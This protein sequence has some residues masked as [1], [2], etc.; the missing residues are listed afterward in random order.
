[1]NILKMASET[2][3]TVRL[4]RGSEGAEWRGLPDHLEHAK[5][6]ERRPER[7]VGAQKVFILLV[8]NIS[9]CADTITI[10]NTTPR[11]VYAAIYYQQI[12]IPFMAQPDAQ[13]AT[14]VQCVDAQ[15][16]ATL[17]RP[18]RWF[19]YDRELVF[20]EDPSLLTG[21]L[22]NDLLHQYHSKNVGNLQGS[23]FYLGD[24]EGDIYAYTVLEWDAVQVPLQ[25]AQQE[26]FNMVPAIA[27]NPYKNQIAY[28]RQGN[29]LCDQEKAYLNKR[30]PRVAK[31]L[32]QF[33]GKPLGVK[34]PTIALVCS[35]GG[36]RAMLYT[37][38]ALKGI[39]ELQLLDAITYAVGL[40]G[41]TWAIG[42][43]I[44]S[45]KSINDFHDWLI[46]N[47]GFDMQNCDEDDFT[48]IGDTILT[49]YCAGQPTGFVDLYGACVAN[50]LLDIFTDN[51][52]EAHISDQSKFITDGSLPLPIYTAISAED[53]ADEDLW[54]EFTPYEVGA[55]WLNS[56]VPTW[57]FGRKF[58][59]GTCVTYAPEQPM[60][61]LLGTFGLAVGI[62][63]K[64]MF[65]EANIQDTM[66]IAILKKLVARLMARYGDDRPISAEYLNF[67]AGIP[68]A[69]FNTLPILHLVDA[70][71][72]F[73]LPF[74]PISGQRPAR[75]ANIIIFIDASSGTVGD[76]LANV[77]NY[78]RAHQL[79]FPGIDY[80]IVGKQAV[81]I[82]KSDTDPNVPVVIYI[83]RIVDQQLLENH[84]NDMPD[85]YTILH[86]F[87]IEKCIAQE[88]CNTFNFQYS[89]QDARKVTALGEFNM[90][91]A[92]DAIMQALSLCS[93]KITV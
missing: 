86:D 1:M 36:Y 37:T 22:S 14:G 7:R 23:T 25:Y 27:H 62:T 26:L 72:N 15:Q 54:Y 47:I 85:L 80:S 57:A 89:P 5:R 77:E 2:N 12:K 69:Q 74:P 40:S 66:K 51:K 53:S 20:V 79:P 92:R 35:G 18:D 42:P 67:I 33:T 90:L 19:G 70:G 4:D 61:T 41:S 68:D 8:F 44:S 93:G 31:A 64:R 63:F 81:S 58:K 73:N 60:G 24:D 21:T 88:A 32:M 59:N 78:A 10:N 30:M 75:K 49:K 34:I 48:L 45:G 83:P 87:D 28:V 39:A 38:G 84:K 50:D 46:N 29:N 71:I 6:D 43:W 17:N 52:I 11:D 55:S 65:Q 56:Y 13:L 82:F 9:L 76:E 16:S 3:L 91:M